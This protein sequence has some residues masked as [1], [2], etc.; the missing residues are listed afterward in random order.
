MLLQLRMVFVFS[1][2][3]GLTDTSSEPQLAPLYTSKRFILG[4]RYDVTT[5]HPSS[6]T[7]SIVATSM[8]ATDSETNTA[9]SPPA[10]ALDTQQEMYKADYYR[11]LEFLRYKQKTAR[12]Q[13]RH[14]LRH[15]I[16]L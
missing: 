2:A 16:L 4:V 12:K 10:E 14:R 13:F 3:Q 5:P 11:R 6:D 7:P 8:T 9:E 1:A 15:R